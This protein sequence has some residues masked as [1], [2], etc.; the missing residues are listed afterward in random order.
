MNKQMKW[1]LALLLMLALAGLACGPLSGGD[2][3]ASSNEEPAA[4]QAQES[5]TAPEDTAS[6]SQPA[7]SDQPADE[8]DKA[9]E[10][11]PVDEPA[12]TF[13]LDQSNNF[14]VPDNVDAYHMSLDF[15]FEETLDD[16]STQSTHVMAD[17]AQIVDPQATSLTFDIESEGQPGIE[18]FTMT[19]IGD[20]NYF[21]LPTGEC[22]AG[23]SGLEDNPFSQFLSPGEFMGGL[24][25]AKLAE[26]DVEVNGVNTDHYVF[27]ESDLI[28]DAAAEAGSLRDVEGHIYVADEG[29]VVRLEMTAEASGS[30]L[31]D[32]SIGDGTLS[33][34]LNFF[35][36]NEPIEILPPE[37]CDASGESADYP[38]LDDATDLASF[39]GV[40]TYQ[41]ATSFDD[42]VAFYQSEM[43]AAGWTTEQ[44]FIGEPTATFVFS[45]DGVEVQISIVGDDA[46]GGN[47]IAIVEQ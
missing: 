5:E 42:A 33:Y 6:G 28:L 37:G 22:I 25:G 41:T 31:A 23:F 38:I 1:I 40:T 27:S 9:A 30:L 7:A 2:D 20:A 3:D 43:E 34:Q 44:Q 24:A 47:I 39:S 45:K 46:T 11:E 15:T 8:S 35:D 17:G 19:Q 21:V 36:I 10:P 26:R 12:E 18:G 16:G 14:G 4:Q 13:G 32:E 29:Y